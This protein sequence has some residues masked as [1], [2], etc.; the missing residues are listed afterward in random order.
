MNFVRAF[1]D[2]VLV[3]RSLAGDDRA[4]ATLYRRHLRYVAGIL[5][6]FARAVGREELDDMLQQTFADAYTGLARL[7]DRSGFRPW[8]ARIAVRC[9]YDRLA[10]R[11]RLLSVSQA[12]ASMGP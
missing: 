3:E 9:A 1:D 7:R 5:Q 6:R 4:F 8:I 12:A 2:A 11:E 10:S